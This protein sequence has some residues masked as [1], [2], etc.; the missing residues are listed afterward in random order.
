MLSLFYHRSFIIL[1]NH[2]DEYIALGNLMKMRW[3]VDLLT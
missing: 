1:S 3:I 2:F